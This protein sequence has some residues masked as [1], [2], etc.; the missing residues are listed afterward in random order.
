MSTNLYANVCFVARSKSGKTTA[1][2]RVLPKFKGFCKVLMS[3]VEKYDPEHKEGMFN[4]KLEY[5]DAGWERLKALITVQ[6]EIYRRGHKKNKM[7]IVLD[8]AISD[9]FRPK[10]LA[11]CLSQC[12]HYNT[13]FIIFT[14]H[15]TS[16]LSPAARA[17]IHVW[18]VGQV[19]RETLEYIYPATNFNDRV[20][21]WEDYQAA[22]K[23]YH[24]WRLNS[25][26][27]PDP[28]RV[29]NSNSVVLMDVCE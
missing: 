27:L 2:K 17:N 28:P 13:K 26:D 14:Q 22:A 25:A 29:I 3:N 9:N 23:K 16:S 19:S 8:D 6:K 18:M 4:E 1:L 7:L 15:I 5:S 12:R 11:E 21:M 10:F 20:Q 24:F